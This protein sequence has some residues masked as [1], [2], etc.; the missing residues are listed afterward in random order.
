MKAIYGDAAPEGIVTNHGV[1]VNQEFGLFGMITSDTESQA[2]RK[3][4]QQPSLSL[5]TRAI[6]I[7]GEALEDLL[8][9]V[10]NGNSAKKD[11]S[12]PPDLDLAQKESKAIENTPQVNEKKD[13]LPQGA[14]DHFIE[15][16]IKKTASVDSL[17]EFHKFLQTKSKVSDFAQVGLSKATHSR[18]ILN[19]P[20]VFS[21]NSFAASLSPSTFS[22]STPIW[23]KEAKKLFTLSL[24]NI[25]LLY[26]FFMHMQTIFLHSSLQ[27]IVRDYLE[28]PSAWLPAEMLSIIVMEGSAALVQILTSSFPEHLLPQTMVRVGLVTLVASSTIFLVLIEQISTIPYWWIYFVCVGFGVGMGALSSAYQLMVPVLI[29]FHQKELKGRNESKQEMCENMIF[30]LMGSSGSLGFGVAY[31]IVGA[32]LDQLE[33][34]LASQIIM[35]YIIIGICCVLLCVHIYHLRI[36]RRR[37]SKFGSV[38]IEKDLR[39]SKL[40]VIL[41]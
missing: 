8:E 24:F 26:H 3:S 30:G 5:P 20:S 7:N 38:R 6:T 16:K 22:I 2:H 27:A 41:F 9:E 23:L 36:I 39:V 10:K 17:E 34:K 13:N 21:T 25:C 37:T 15:I 4:L 18:K 33:L 12:R 19:T 11:T 1:D 40:S 31:F 32:L 35:G 29:M 14:D 28:V